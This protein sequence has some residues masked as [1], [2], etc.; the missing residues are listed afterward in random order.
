MP[1]IGR[2]SLCKNDVSEISPKNYNFTTYLQSRDEPIQVRNCKRNWLP[3][4]TSRQKLQPSS[5]TSIYGTLSGHRARS[6]GFANRMYQRFGTALDTLTMGE[7][8]PTLPPIFENG[9]ANPNHPSIQSFTK[10]REELMTK[11]RSQRSGKYPHAFFTKGITLLTTS[12]RRIPHLPLT[13]SQKSKLNHLKHQNTGARINMVHLFIHR[14]QPRGALPR[15]D[16]QHRKARTG[17]HETLANRAKDAE[18]NSAPL[19]SRSNGRPRMGVWRSL[20]AGRDVYHF[21]CSSN[22]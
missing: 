12:R 9:V 8:T 7:N 13:N 3:F 2:T 10:A 17:N 15:N 4:S 20:R 14:P 6:Q 19:P 22:R 18:R 5:P 11:E 21:R 1:S 16:V